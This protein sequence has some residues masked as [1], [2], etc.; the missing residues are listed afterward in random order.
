MNKQGVDTAKGIVIVAN[1]NSINNNNATD[2]ERV[3]KF[4]SIAE[5]GRVRIFYQLFELP[6]N[7]IFVKYRKFE[8]VM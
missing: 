8:F 2:D 3:K 4:S 6:Y 5:Y 1:N 7:V